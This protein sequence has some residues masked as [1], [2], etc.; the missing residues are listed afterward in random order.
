MLK[1][2]IS[3]LLLTSDESVNKNINLKLLEAE[4][5]LMNEGI[6]FKRR[7]FSHKKEAKNEKLKKNNPN[8]NLSIKLTEQY[9]YKKEK[10]K[11]NNQNY[12]NIPMN[13]SLSK[14]SSFIKNTHMPINDYTKFEIKTSNYKKSNINT[15]PYYCKSPNNANNKNILKYNSSKKYK[16]NSKKSFNNIYL[17]ENKDNKNIKNKDN[18]NILINSNNSPRVT[19]TNTKLQNGYISP[20]DK[21]KYYLN[22]YRNSNNSTNRDNKDNRYKK[23]EEQKFNYK[24]WNKITINNIFDKEKDKDRDKNKNKDNDIHLDNY[25]EKEKKKIY[26][27]SDIKINDNGIQEIVIQNFKKEKKPKINEIP[28]DRKKNK[29]NNIMINSYL[30][31]NNIFNYCKNMSNLALNKENQNLNNFT[32]ETVNGIKFDQIIR[33]PEIKKSIKINKTNSLKKYKSSHKKSDSME[34]ILFD[35]KNNFY[36]RDSYSELKIQKTSSKNKSSSKKA[37]KNANINSNKKIDNNYNIENQNIFRNK[38]NL[39]SNSNSELNTQIIKI[40]NSNLLDFIK[41]TNSSNN[42][43]NITKS[44]KEVKINKYKEENIIKQDDNTDVKNNLYENLNEEIFN[45]NTDLLAEKEK[46]LNNYTFDN[47]CEIDSEHSFKVLNNYNNIFDN[48]SVKTK[49]SQNNINENSSSLKHNIFTKKIIGGINIKNNHL[50]VINLSEKNYN[51]KINKINDIEKE[52]ISNNINNKFNGD[53]VELAKIC[54]N[55][56]KIISDLVKNVQQLNNQICDK[57][58]CINELN[59]QLYSIKYDLLNTL[60]KTNSK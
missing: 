20:I 54:A 23:Y 18:Y 4:Q 27:K 49:I 7:I 53:Y 26:N 22:I 50:N 39:R 48:I 52:N 29:N 55:Q 12:T 37:Y 6:I 16:N 60:Q 43:N 33:S 35:N 25:G 57:D 3:N 5:R 46:G 13:L 2:E 32:Q 8:K 40:K 58:L 1:N 10:D 14:R 21:S 47:K 59:N 51:K 44:K 24:K 9:L 41:N 28:C 17:K 38:Y 31:K 36:S 45:T 42:I 56:E 34:R 11:E 15:N 19:T 30:D